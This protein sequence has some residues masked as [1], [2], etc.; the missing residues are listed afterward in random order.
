MC[1]LFG[2]WCFLS[3][4]HRDFPN[5]QPYEALPSLCFKLVFQNEITLGFSFID[6][7][8]AF[9]KGSSIG[10]ERISPATLTKAVLT[11]CA[12]C[13]ILD[14]PTQLLS[15]I[16]RSPYPIGTAPWVRI[17]CNAT[18]F[19]HS[20]LRCASP[21]YVN[22]CTLS[23]SPIS[24]MW[25]ERIH[26]QHRVV[27]TVKTSIAATRRIRSSLCNHLERLLLQLLRWQ[28]RR[29]VQ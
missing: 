14:I 26:V 18:C 13:S 15:N 16:S 22:V 23:E 19:L 24:E 25:F 8:S 29:Q 21:K 1:Q 20:V 27:P 11:V 17:Q 3:G 4:R 5:F 2:T 7:D 10:R 9:R 12:N 6:N 28:K